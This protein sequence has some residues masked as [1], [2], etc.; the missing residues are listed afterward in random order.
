MAHLSHQ[1]LQWTRPLLDNMKRASDNDKLDNMKRHLNVYSSFQLTMRSY[2]FVLH[3]VNKLM[4]IMRTLPCA[5]HTLL[6]DIDDCLRLT[7]S[8]ITKVNITDEQFRHASLPVKSGGIGVRSI[9][10][11]APSAFLS[12]STNAQ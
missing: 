11:I 12:S 1:V 3:A 7:L 4:H 10:S 6:S 9:M 2:S 5:G 8:N